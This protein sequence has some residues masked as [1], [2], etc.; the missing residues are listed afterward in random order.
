MDRI[1]NETI[2]QNID[3]LAKKIEQK[4]KIINTNPLDDQLETLK[5][6]RNNITF[7]RKKLLKRGISLTICS[8]IVLGL[9]FGFIPK[10]SKETKYKTVTTTY[11]QNKAVDK[12]EEYLSK[13]NANN[14]EIKE[15]EPYFQGRSVYLRDVTSYKFSSK[16]LDK[17]ENYFKLDLNKINLYE[18]ERET[19]LSLDIEDYYKNNR[20]EVLITKQDT[21]KYKT[22]YDT[23]MLLLYEG[24][25]ICSLSVILSCICVWRLKNNSRITDYLNHLSD[26]KKDYMIQEKEIKE[27]LDKLEQLLKENQSLIEKFNESYNKFI[28]QYGTTPEI[29]ELYKKI[30]NINYSNMNRKILKLSPKYNDTV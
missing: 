29:D 25:L 19:K 4:D 10:L 7:L 30:N 24:W 6:I 23:F 26:E 5:L 1:E 15:C 14:I 16:T 18:K 9:G 22:E 12:T 17:I 20:R 3:L 13:M 28:I 27:V 11:I 21:D 2:K 8:T